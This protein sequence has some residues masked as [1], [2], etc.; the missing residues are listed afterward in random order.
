MLID[1]RHILYFVWIVTTL[2]LFLLIPK[3]KVRLALVA[4]LFNQVITWP[5]GLFV[6]E[7]GW[8]EYPIRFFEKANKASFTFEY[9]F[10]PV[11]CVYFNVYF[12]DGKPLLVRAAYYTLFCSILTLAEL[13]ILQHTNLIR[14]IHWNAY[15]SWVT[16]CIT[17]YITRK[18]CLWFFKHCG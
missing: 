3:S 9:F 16:L 10:Y 14:Y 5:V 4:F 6:A 11:M 18:F 13:L 17:F 2:S 7:M 15:L 8:V 12:P 1:G